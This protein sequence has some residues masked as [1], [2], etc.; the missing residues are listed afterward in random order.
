MEIRCPITDE[1]ILRITPNGIV[2][3]VNYREV[4]FNLSDGSKMRMALSKSAVDN[5]KESQVDRLFEA[6][7]KQRTDKIKGKVL[8]KKVRERQLERIDKTAITRVESKLGVIIDKLKK[9][10][11]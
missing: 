8:D 7:K 9:Y 3:R 4:W 6:I 11:K 2:Q 5:L 10:D 1:V